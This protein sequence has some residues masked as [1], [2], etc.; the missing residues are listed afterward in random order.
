VHV[1]GSTQQLRYRLGA[2]ALALLAATPLVIGSTLAADDRGHGTH[3]QL[4]LPACMW[5][6]TLDTPCPT[7]GMTTSFTSVSTGSLAAG[8]A[9]QP[10][11]ALLAVAAAVMFWACLHAAATGIR[12]AALAAPLL[13]PRG[14][15]IIAGLAGGAWLYKI[16]TW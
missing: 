1:S 14:L 8:F 12:G 15:W 6:A 10:L 3:E 4:G 13:T 7:C 2:L 5:A 11:G 16:V 9:A